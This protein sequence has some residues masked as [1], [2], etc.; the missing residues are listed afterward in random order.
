M[1]LH[2]KIINKVIIAR[3]LV[4]FILVYYLFFPAF[5]ICAAAL[6]TKSN[7]EGSTN[8]VN[9]VLPTLS[10]TAPTAV[11][12]PTVFTEAVTTPV[13]IN[14]PVLFSELV[15]T[16]TTYSTESST[17]LKT[18][19]LNCIDSLNTA[20]NSG[21][22][23]SS[24]V[25]AMS[26]ELSRL[27]EV[28]LQL[29]SDIARYTKWEQEYYYAAKTWEFFMQRG[30][31]EAVVAGIIGNMM[32][33]TSGGTLA[34]KPHV[35]GKGHYGLCQ[36]SLYYRPNVADMPFESQLVYLENDLEKEFNTFGFCYKQNFGY[37]EFLAL[38][39][40]A[41]AAKAFAKVY[42]RPGDGTYSIR[43]NAAITAYNYF[44]L[45]D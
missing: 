23:T 34:L 39:D 1:K 40:P 29:D 22:Y 14:E 5:V 33:E 38:D 15:Y 11:T 43:Q 8:E 18:E 28:I 45:G 12:D 2:K 19:V 37:E 24:A 20:I 3:V 21:A 44:V 25:N 16:G 42:E 10:T 27:N 32:I 30:Y 35:Y 36:W 13:L 7:N 26:E 41:A 17:Q 31:K 4:V 6:S 9:T